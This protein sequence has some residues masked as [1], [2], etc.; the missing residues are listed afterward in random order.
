VV[1]ISGG[2]GA[3]GGGGPGTQTGLMSLVS[4]VTRMIGNEGAVRFSF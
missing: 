3:T 4:G 2:A 1:N